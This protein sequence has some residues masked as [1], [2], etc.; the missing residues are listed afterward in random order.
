MSF[1]NLKRGCPICGGIRK[2][3]RQNNQNQVIHCRHADANPVGYKFLKLDKLGFGM[4]L[5]SAI[6]DE[7]DEQRRSEW[8]LEQQRSREARIAAELQ[9]SA[10]G[11]TEK[12]RDREFRN[13]L[14]QLSLSPKHR[15]D[16]L[17]RGLTDEQINQGMFA[18]VKKWQ[19]LSSPV[20]HLL[21]GVNIDGRSLNIGYSGYLCPIW[22]DG[23]IIGCQVR[24]DSGEGKYRWLTSV[25]KKRPNGQTSHLKNGELP[26]TIV[27]VDGNTD[28]STLCDTSVAGSESESESEGDQDLRFAEGI[29]K[30]Y[31]ASSRLEKNFL[32]AAGGNFANSPLQVEVVI[33]YLNPERL[34][35]C[36]DAGAVNNSQV[37]R[38]YQAL[39]ELVSDLGRELWVEWW[40]QFDKT[41][42]DI[43]ELSEETHT[44][45]ISYQEFCEFS[46]VQPT[47]TQAPTKFLTEQQWWERYGLPNEIKSLTAF[48]KK[49]YN[50]ATD[51]RGFLAEGRGQRGNSKR[52]KEEWRDEQKDYKLG[53]SNPH[54]DEDSPY[55]NSGKGFAPKNSKCDNTVKGETLIR[56]RHNTGEEKS[57]PLPSAICH[58]PSVAIVK[59]FP[60]KKFYTPPIQ[61]IPGQFPEFEIWVEMGCP[62]VVFSEGDRKTLIA[63]TYQ[64]GYHYV[65]DSSAPAQGKSH[66]SGEIDL[67]LLGIEVGRGQKAEGRRQRDRYLKDSNSH[68]NEDSLYKDSAKGFKPINI[69]VDVDQGHHEEWCNEQKNQLQG[70]SDSSDLKSGVFLRAHSTPSALCP[71]PSAFQS[72]SLIDRDAASKNPRIF[73]IDSN[74][75]NP[76][77]ATVEKRYKPLI[78]RHQGLDYDYSRQT[79]S[80]FPHLVR[81]NRTTDNPSPDI[82]PPCELWESY[83][84]MANKD[85]VVFGGIDSPICQVCPHF[86]NCKYLKQRADTLN[87]QQYISADINGMSNPSH[88]DIGI[89][90]EAG[91]SLENTKKISVSLIEIEK[92]IGRL[93]VN[94]KDERIYAAL[95]P[96]LDAIHDFLTNFDAENKKYGAHHREIVNQLPSRQYLESLIWD[97]FSDDWLDVTNDVWGKPEWNYRFT[98]APDGSISEK[99]TL[100]Y[101]QWI[102]PSLYDLAAECDRILW[103]NLES[104]LSGHQSPEEKAELI[105]QN[106]LF[107]W[108]SPLLKVLSGSKQ[109]SLQIKNDILQIT[110]PFRRHQNIVKGF[111]F[112]VFLDATLSVADLKQKLNL[113]TPILEIQQTAPDNSNL[114]INV[115]KGLGHCGKQRQSKRKVNGKYILYESAYSLSNRIRAAIEKIYKRHQGQSIAI[116]DHKTFEKEYDNL[117]QQNIINK[118]GYWYRDTRGTNRFLDTEVMINVGKPT[119]NLGDLAAQWQ[120]MTRHIVLPTQLTGEYG[121]WVTR[122]IVAEIVQ[123]IGRLRAHIRPHQS[124]TSWH[125]CNLDNDEIE[126]IKRAFPGATINII[127]A[128]DLV[129]EAANKGEQTRRGVIKAIWQG[130]EAGV[131]RTTTEIGTD[132]GVSRS[133]VSRVVNE[134]ISGGL[135]HFYRVCEILYK[136]IN[137]KT[138]TLEELNLTDEEQWIAREYL[139]AIVAD[140]EAKAI[141]A[142]VALTDVAN[143][144]YYY[145]ETAFKRILAATPLQTLLKLCSAVVAC[146]PE[147]A[148]NQLKNEL[149]DR[150]REERRHLCPS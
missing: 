47:P 82:A 22:H 66:D 30:P 142:S 83:R 42:A 69:D 93:V 9:R 23:L 108:I 72:R 105:R 128:Y 116:I 136:A 14:G 50:R 80:G 111:G 38:S 87:S 119:P 13:L 7:Q 29:L 134:L 126:A 132:V 77:T 11:L 62:K 130:V 16:L 115:I 92:T 10:A 78:A 117:I 71:L 112:S 133:R 18:S 54:K 124:L 147:D 49:Y 17:R 33:A 110:K 28:K 146:L 85:W 125:L 45:I 43:D 46:T 97:L 20:S 95:I 86:S 68:L 81:H 141:S 114:T 26:I 127:V 101:I 36:P 84:E 15:E 67:E 99:A 106:V 75:R 76:S 56:L 131:R 51:K 123:D 61:Y 113:D 88:R 34:I 63:E 2:D 4:W 138:H 139:T 65:K 21:P 32:G 39:Y 52:Q 89:I 91:T 53:D 96:I 135:K 48:I 149:E 129:P 74:Y 5:E 6:I 35:L 24:L 60:P 109:Y 19:K 27:Q 79:P 145:G 41:A 140:L 104:L 144:A 37:M 55:G 25:N 57:N 98:Q 90:E 150:E 102:V 12:E 73:R 58:L 118:F 31:V 121:A 107:N 100:D 3:C 59:W 103:T 1:T 40:G 137:S 94:S 8:K 70:N 148:L 44:T 143:V 120:T 64:K 122:Q